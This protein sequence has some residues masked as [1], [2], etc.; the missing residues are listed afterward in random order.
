MIWKG[1]KIVSNKEVYP[2]KPA[3]LFF[4]QA[5]IKIIKPRQEVL[6]VGTGSGVVAIAVGKFVKGS[7][8]IASDINPEA[9]SVA[10]QNA[11]INK[12]KVDF[13]RGDF[14]KPFKGKKF[15]AMLIHPPAIAYP[16]GETW[17]MSKGMT[18]ATNGGP[19]GSKLVIKSIVESK[20]YLKPKGKLFLLLPH[21]SN[22]KLAYKALRSNYSSIKTLA[23]KRVE[24]FP[25][26]E[27]KP[28]KKVL[29]HARNL[30]KRG[31]I[32]LH[33]VKGRAFS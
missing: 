28:N 6:E 1:L 20:K 16:K 32:E 2:P 31:I 8:V 12:V 21:W 19:D 5:V 15:D 17:G 4:A 10:K 11:E 14:L 24:F 23:K 13:I 29:E 22:T 9:I 26:S 18:I 3:S 33:F 7:K 27:G 25:L 30:A